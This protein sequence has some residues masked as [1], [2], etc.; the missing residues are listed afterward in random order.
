[1]A[2]VNCVCWVIF[3][4]TKFESVNFVI[5]IPNFIG[6]LLCLSQILVWNHYKQKSLNLNDNEKKLVE[7]ND[8]EKDPNIFEKRNEFLVQKNQST[9]TA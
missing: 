6:T 7:M 5:F 2:V 1:M 4:L 9:R 8:I 3:S